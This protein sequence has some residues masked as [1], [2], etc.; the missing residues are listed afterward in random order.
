MMVGMALIR[1]LARPLIAGTFVYGGLDTLRNPGP[2]VPAADKV[3]RPLVSAVPQLSDTEQVVKLDAV[4]KV[5]AGGML[6]LGRFPRLSAAAL[7]ASLIPTT[8]AG[9]RFWEK[10]DRAE[11]NAQLLHFLKNASIVGGL[12][13]AAVDTA[14]KPSLAWRAQHAPH[15]LGHAAGDLRR[16]A[17]LARYS[18]GDSVHSLGNSVRDLLTG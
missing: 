2:R 13:L 8:V 7:A 5:V 4:V 15:A 16:E 10:S 6:A 9:H 14:G 12:M 11:R 3:V 18:A 1:R 17:E